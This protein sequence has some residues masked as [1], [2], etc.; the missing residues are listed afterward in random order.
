MEV[1]SIRKVKKVYFNMGEAWE[2]QC[3]WEKRGVEEEGEGLSIRASSLRRPDIWRP[4]H[5]LSQPGTGGGGGLGWRRQQ[6]G[7]S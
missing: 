6:Q 7:G 2:G 1:T 4:G 3:W 5:S